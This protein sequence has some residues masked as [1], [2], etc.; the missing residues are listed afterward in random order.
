[1]NSMNCKRTYASLGLP[2]AIG[3]IAGLFASLLVQAAEPTPAPQ[4]Q[5]AQKME[6]VLPG[7]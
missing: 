2:V 3:L 6:V 5:G 4:N 1:M 7:S